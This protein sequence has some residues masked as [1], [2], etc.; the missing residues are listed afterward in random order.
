MY[1]DSNSVVSTLV[2][3][4][5]WDAALN[6]VSDAEHNIEFAGSWGNFSNSTGAAATNSGEAN[7]NYTTGRNEAWQ[8]K[9]IYDL[10]GNMGE[11]T[12]EANG[13][14]ERISRRGSYATSSSC[15]P[16]ERVGVDF[17]WSGYLGFRVALYIK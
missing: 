2:Y 15:G 13:K 10:A 12:M 1:K 3:G 14:Y 4:V 8:A 9:N 11:W 16:Y 6:F 17:D 7:M 5:Q